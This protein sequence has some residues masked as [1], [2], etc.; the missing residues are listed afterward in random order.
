VNNNIIKRDWSKTALLIF[1]GGY[2]L[3]IGILSSIYL[4]HYSQIEITIATVWIGVLIL[5]CALDRRYRIL[6]ILIGIFIIIYSG[7][8]RNII[9][10]PVVLIISLICIGLLFILS[11]IISKQLKNQN[12][13]ICIGLIIIIIFYPITTIL[14]Q[15]IFAL[16]FLIILFVGGLFYSVK[17]KEKLIAL[18]IIILIITVSSSFLIKGEHRGYNYNYYISINPSMSSN[19]ELIIPIALDPDEKVHDLMNHLT[20]KQGNAEY[21]IIN[22]SYGFGLQIIGTGRFLISAKFSNSKTSFF[23]KQLE[24]PKL[25]HLSMI[26]HS[27]ERYNYYW[28]YVNNSDNSSI[29]LF[30]NCGGE[31]SKSSGSLIQMPW[32]AR[33][34]GPFYEIYEDTKGTGWQLIQGR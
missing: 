29:H 4:N 15:T 13:T 5:G 12:K 30:V 31:R 23:A 11:A 19:Y 26:N 34:G 10:K 20:I 32:L 7:I 16:L 25:P 18:I 33:G 28:I 21:K 14:T 6:L 27:E 2:F 3:S 1:I 9:L 24:Y 22:T 8:I 17:K